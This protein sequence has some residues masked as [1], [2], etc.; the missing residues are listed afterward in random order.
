LSTN[1]VHDRS[2]S[3][4]GEPPDTSFDTARLEAEARGSGPEPAINPFDPATYKV[5]QSLAAAAG[6]KKHLVELAVTAP[7]KTWW[8]RRHPDDAYSR[9][10]W[11][12]VL[13]DER[14]TYLVLPDLWKSLAGEATFKLMALYLAMTMQGKPFLWSVK[15]PADDTREPA[16]WMRAPLQAVRLAKDNWTRIS[17]NEETRQHD[18]VTVE[19]GVEPEWPNL[20]MPQLM[21]LAFKGFIV[22]TLEHP[23]IRRLRGKSR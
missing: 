19:S 14:E 20:S 3:D 2:C 9:R 6:V 11:F 4:N 1:K 16:K 7:D 17:W 13:K 8:V 18:V 15:I 12:I 23:V 10:S 5:E 21:E 22:D